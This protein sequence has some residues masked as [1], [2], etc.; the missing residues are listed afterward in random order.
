MKTAKKSTD[1]CGSCGKPRG[2]HRVRRIFVEAKGLLFATKMKTAGKG[3]AW[4]PDEVCVKLQGEKDG[5]LLMVCGWTGEPGADEAWPIERIEHNLGRI[6]EEWADDFSKSWK[7]E[8]R[9][10]E[11]QPIRG[12]NTDGPNRRTGT[13]RRADKRRL[14]DKSEALI[15]GR[16]KR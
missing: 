11:N 16:R 15:A 14:G 9:R 10:S 2:E 4:M 6:A 7:L 12:R 8:V 5:K 1:L 13:E 3:I